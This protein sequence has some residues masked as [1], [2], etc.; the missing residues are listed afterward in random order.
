MFVQTYDTILN[1]FIIYVAVVA[2]PLYPNL[3]Q[4]LAL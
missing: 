4:L 3:K 1:V 2:F